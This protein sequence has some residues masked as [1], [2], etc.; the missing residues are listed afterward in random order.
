MH[1]FLLGILQ[2]MCQGM[3]PPI[4]LSVEMPEWKHR[5]LQ[6]SPALNPHSSSLPSSV[7]S[8][9]MLMPSAMMMLLMRMMVDQHLYEKMKIDV[10]VVVVIVIAI[11]VAVAITIQQYQE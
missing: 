7:S 8:S 2:C 9:T 10:V 4:E 5:L 1:Y 3:S 11:V 6:W